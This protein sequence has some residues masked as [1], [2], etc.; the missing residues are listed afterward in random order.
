MRLNDNLQSAATMRLLMTAV[1]VGSLGLLSACA[2]SGKNDITG[3][4]ELTLA[5]GDTGQCESSPCRVL[6]K[7]PAGTGTYEVTGNEAT[8]GTYPAGK[9]ADLGSF[10][11]S[12]AFAIKGMHVPKAYA[13]IPNRP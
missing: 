9:T 2:T 11:Q 4:D 6:L 10:D 13:Y 12:Q 7:M 3:F 5:P 8:V 1:L